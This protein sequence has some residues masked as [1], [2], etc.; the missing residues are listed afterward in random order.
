MKSHRFYKAVATLFLLNTILIPLPTAHADT[1]TDPQR[2]STVASLTFEGPVSLSSTVAISQEIQIQ[3][4]TSDFGPTPPNLG[5]PF[6]RQ[7]V[8]W[9]MEIQDAASNPRAII[10]WT[11]DQTGQVTFSFIDYNENNQ[12]S[13]N[14]AV[15]CAQNSRSCTATPTTWNLSDPLRVSFGPDQLSGKQWWRAIVTDLANNT[16]LDLGSVQDLTLTNLSKFKVLDYINRDSY[17]TDCPGDAAPIA[18]TYFG[19]IVD[20]TGAEDQYADKTLIVNSCV[21]AKFGSSYSYTGAYLLYGG[22]VASQTSAPREYSF[23]PSSLIPSALPPMPDAPSNLVFTAS[24]SVLSLYIQVPNLV[25]QGVQKAFLVSP[26]LGFSKE[27]PLFSKELGLTTKFEIPITQNLLG[28]TIHLSFYTQSNSQKSNPYVE[29]VTIPQDA[30]AQNANAPTPTPKPTPKPTKKSASKPSS[31]SSPKPT[32]KPTPKQS[33][34]PTAKPTTSPKPISL[35]PI[36]V[37]PQNLNVSISGSVL[38]I[39]ADSIQ[40]PGT[41]VVGCLLVAPLFNGGSNDPIVGDHGQVSGNSVLFGIQLNQSDA[42]KTVDFT[43]ALYNGAGTSAAVSGSYTLPL[44]IPN[45]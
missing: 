15:T 41:P 11:Y 42:G 39:K 7:S 36:P 13:N 21:N 19:P 8:R 43:L 5:Y 20:S 40:P 31:K 22:T 9:S 2:P 33:T 24:N 32:S 45:P 35:A 26:E 25:S 28:T 27:A 37:A 14:S 23:T 16:T 4:L 38:I 44:T 3:P 6:P 12:R 29:L 17:A 30:L 34:K 1:K 18:D 10:S